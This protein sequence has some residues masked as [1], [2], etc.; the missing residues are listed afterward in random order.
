MNEALIDRY[1]M[2]LNA[3]SAHTRLAYEKDLRDFASFYQG[4]SLDW[5]CLEAKHITRFFEAINQDKSVNLKA[6]TLNRKLSTLRSFYRFLNREGIV[7]INPVLRVKSPKNQRHLPDFL[8][9]EEVLKLLESFD[10]NTPDGY[11]NRVLFELM[12]ACGLRV[13]EA[14]QLSLE[15][16]NLHDRS[17][18]FVG[19]GNKERLVPFYPDIQ[20]KLKTYLVS[21]RPILLK[22]KRHNRVFVGRSGSS[23]SSRSVQF[24]LDESAKKA[25][26]TRSLHPHMLRHSFATH[27]LDNGADLRVVQE[28]LGHENL[29]TTQIYTHVSLDRLKE[30]YLKAHPRAKK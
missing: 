5:D 13:S 22:D 15:N 16:V 23:L 2:Q 25:G 28:L 19:K 10:L 18:R 9:F 17:L 26:I 20:E 4:E 24:I 1:L 12:Y 27:L 29:S 8:M 21:I 30:S 11:R 3:N 6:S 14:T 7:S